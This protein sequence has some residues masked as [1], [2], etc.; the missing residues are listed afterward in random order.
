MRTS[1]VTVM[2]RYSTVKRRGN[3]VL[4]YDIVQ[5]E[6][7]PTQMGI[8]SR[9]FENLM[10]AARERNRGVFLEQCISPDSKAFKEKLIARGVATP[11]GE[12]SAL[13]VL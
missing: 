7:N 3:D 6:V 11:Y 8:G 13:S 5:I 2:L 4:D 12:Y 9:F 10:I 1:F